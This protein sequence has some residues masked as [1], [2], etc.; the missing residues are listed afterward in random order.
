MAA[1]LGGRLNARIYPDWAAEQER[2]VRAAC[3][4][5]DAAVTVVLDDA[6]VV[7]FVTV[8]VTPANPPVRST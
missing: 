7:G 2:G 4:D 1:V 6:D 5:P 3:T 8:V